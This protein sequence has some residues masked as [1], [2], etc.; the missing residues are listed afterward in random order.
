MP[1]NVQPSDSAILVT[2]GIDVSVGCTI[3]YHYNA[4]EGC[5]Y[6]IYDASDNCLCEYIFSGV[7]NSGG[8]GG[9]FIVDDNMHYI[10]F[11]P[12][13]TLTKTFRVT[14]ADFISDVNDLLALL[15]RFNAY[16]VSEYL[17]QGI[18]NLYLDSSSDCY[19]NAEIRYNAETGT[20]EW[21]IAENNE[22]SE[23]VSLS[24]MQG[25]IVAAT[26]QQA[27]DASDEAT[28][29]A[30][31]ANAD[32]NIAA[33]AAA[34][35]S[36]Y[37]TEAANHAG[38]AAS[39]AS[40]SQTAA[41]NADRYASDAEE[42]AN[43]AREHAESLDTDAIDAKIGLK[44]DNLWRDPDTGLLY[45]TSNGQTIGD[46][47]EVAT[48]GGGGGGASTFT[49]TLTNLMESRVITVPEGQTVVLSLNYSSVDDEGMDDGPGVGQIL[50]GGV[51]RKTFS[52]NQGEFSVDVTSY[53]A[54]G[55]NNISVKVTNSENVTKTMTYTITVAA[56]SLTSSFDA[57]VPYTGVI[58]FPY[59]P[60][61]IAEK[62]MHFELD[63][64]EIG[65][66]VVTTSG[67]QQSYTIP[68][69]GHG[70][71]VLR[72]WFDCTIEGTKISSNV[73]YYCIVC[74][75]EGNMKPIIALTTPV[76]G[77]VEQF[78]NSA[79][80]YRVHD[81]ASL[82]AAITLEA[83]GTTV[84]SL[85]VDRTEQT[86]SYQPA[87]VGELIR[88]IRCR[89]EYVSWTSTV[90]ESSI[91]VEAETEALALHLSSY[92]R[93]NNEANPGVWESNG[94][95]AE[96]E[97]FNFV[98]DGWVLDDDDITVLRV[99]GDARLTIP[100]KI[101]AYDFRTTGK[102][103]EF[104]L[105]TRQVLDY[106]AVVLSCYSGGRGFVITA[107]Q[108]RMASEQSSLGSR[109]KEDEHIRVSIV[110]E[111]KTENRLLLC[112]INGIMSGSVQYPEDDD[113]SQA[114]PVGITIGSNDCTVDL[115]N[116]RAYDNSLTR[117]QV[118]DNWIADTQK[119]EDRVDRYK[120]ND[121][122]DV[123]G[124]VVISKLPN[125]LPY[126]VI[127]SLK[128]PQFKGD[129]MKCSGYFVDPLHPER[130]FSFVDAEIDVQGT[131]SQYYWRK[132]YK[133]KFKGG[134]IL[135]DGT[136][137]VVYAMNENAVPVSVYTMK[138]DVASS[139]GYYNVVSAKLFNQYHPFKMPA[140][141]ADPRTRY[142][143]DGFPMVIFWDNGTETKFLGKYNFN[144]DKGTPEPFGLA[145]GDERWEVLQNGTARVGFH[146]ADFSDES[147]KEDFEGNFP[148][149]NTDLSNLQPMC[150]WVTSTDTEQA[151]GAAITPVTYDGVE[152]TADTAEYRLAKFKVELPDHFVE[153]AV[154]YYM[155]FTEGF[156]CMD[157]R[158]K[159]VI[160][161]YISA[162][163]RWIADEYDGDSIIG[164]NNQAQP[165]FDY[166][167]EDIDYTASGDP[168]FNGQNSTFWKNIRATKA[169][170]L[171]AEWH[172]L[173]DAG[174]SYASVM[175]DFAEHKSKWPE[176]IY[177]E[178]MQAKCLD[179]LIENGDATYL[180][181]LRGDKWSWTQWWMYNRFRYLD[182]K[183]EY[184][185][186]ME[187]RAT[188]RT[189]VMQNITA[190]YYMKLYGHCY[191]NAEHVV[192][193]V[194]KDVPCEFVSHATGAEDRV[195][196][197]N[198]AD[199]ITD[200]GDLSGHQVELIDLSKMIR[201]KSLKLGDGAQGYVN[202]ALNSVTFGN[203]ILLRYVNIQN[204]TALT[205]ALDMSGCT[206]IEE[207]YCD[208][209]SITGLKLPNG[210]VLKKLHLP[211]TM[212]NLTLLNQTKLTEFVIP[213]SANVTTLWIENVSD[214]VDSAAIAAQMP[215][216][217]RVRM[218][219]VD[220]NLDS[221]DFLD[222]MMQMRGLTETG[223]NTDK[224]V[225][226][227]KAYVDGALTVE[228]YLTYRDWFPYLEITAK[229]FEVLVTSGWKLF[230]TA[231]GKLFRFADG[232]HV[233][234][235]TGEDID[236]YIA[237]RT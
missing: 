232:G 192:E 37:S 109:Y 15:E 123:Y 145:A 10:L 114:S 128:L 8:R 160:W 12:N 69:Q 54:A 179:A 104:E 20:L 25:A 49:V 136:T 81:P 71:H 201:L 33:N 151:T 84:A 208:G 35:A 207:I 183:Y 46:G 18:I 97:N 107:Q 116:I 172:R 47:I 55:T 178:D 59:T 226:S 159:N 122:Y 184:G 40:A 125:D 197:L 144:N 218:T 229:T 186:S 82:T 181:F 130:N 28:A 164:H 214:V 177:N 131:S 53:L 42:S 120:R 16:N 117:Y 58:S 230:R 43:L 44:A 143:I 215:A 135:F 157:Q 6:S 163:R 148:D 231:D 225:I 34:S 202:N 138:A 17:R 11:S 127:S 96:F 27:K 38:A 222:H 166:W 223:D 119:I 51:I 4:S 86:W 213:S 182:S 217:S 221:V 80:R 103:L 100:Y 85:T 101:F 150:A 90:T 89:D 23:L 210:G 3:M 224:A 129:K 204:C 41:N 175:A 2:C 87:E 7:D 188:I 176:A 78:A 146:S 48:G 98:S 216:G 124:Q 167:M 60:V 219:N 155:V 68:A 198:D 99:T 30:E 193:R 227:G 102:T 106:D 173:R 234:D 50:V 9:G 191:Y 113:F 170:A 95:A 152:Y 156:L 168:V 180:P 154:I 162:L 70:A 5:S 132:N 75:V 142:S 220:W 1:I 32:A 205:Q 158:E 77:S 56:V 111:K 134:F 14:V 72:A 126:L 31:V 161:R 73:L 196:G 147:W 62:T 45:L 22:W 189:N 19:H 83:N 121:V 187:N 66:A 153:E 171:K 237:E 79:Q 149:G 194:E 93:S 65:T 64:V 110:T 21:R 92:G 61:G 118:L 67:R 137:A 91:K 133:I 206:N 108:L 94:I 115:Y 141:V 190:T 165:V 112:Y 36:S 195:I 228:Q 52:V 212:A 139:E 76:L 235:Y 24:D 200:L 174:F 199:M 209:A 140:Q 57:S 105:A 39:A 203:N 233:T 236:R 169:D 88:T 63:G 211:G 74:T 185:T 26:L 29:A 13:V